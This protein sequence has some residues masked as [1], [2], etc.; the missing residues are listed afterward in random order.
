MKKIKREIA[1]L[2][3]KKTG[4]SD[5]FYEQ[6]KNISFE[7]SIG[8][9]PQDW[10]TIHFK[11]YPRMPKISLDK[12]R[13]KKIKSLLNRRSIRSF[14]RKDSS[15]KLLSELIYT[16]AGLIILPKDID[17]SR[18]S[19]P[20]AGARYPLEL[21]IVSLNVKGLNEGLY[22]YNVKENLLEEL[23]IQNMT[24]WILDTTGNERWILDASFLIIITGI[25][26]RSRA[27]YGER[28]FRY[29]LIEVGHLSQNICLLLDSLGLG[30][31]PIG[32]FIESN[33]ISLLDI[34]NIRE[35]PLCILAIG[36]KNE[37]T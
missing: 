11:T 22:H 21:Y 17:S 34:D 4:I 2:I 15:L 7:N 36:K 20:S 26:D 28:G 6:S 27:K 24:D 18:R 33:V 3:N 30:A 10:I 35:Y 9:I 32:G 8:A 1:E 14:A 37:R 13:S 12:T 29:M 5:M 16:T 19:Y 25:P 31:C 23:L